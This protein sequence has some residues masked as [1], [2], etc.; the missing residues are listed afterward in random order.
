MPYITTEQVKTIRAALKKHFPFVKMSI[1]K[2]HCSTVC[3]TI[4][5]STIDFGLTEQ[6]NHQQVNPFWI[7]KNYEHLPE[8][9]DFLLKLK[10]TI[11][12]AHECR[13]VSYDYDY[14]SIPN[15]YIDIDIGQ[16]D[17]PYQKLSA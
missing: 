2:Q 13:E 4:L 12:S 14:G 6:H 15:Y 3:V 16:W 8:A 10:E 7:E 5:Q 17:K 1:R 11:E 9:R